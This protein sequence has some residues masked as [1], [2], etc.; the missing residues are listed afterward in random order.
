MNQLKELPS[1]HYLAA[2]N[3]QQRRFEEILLR[4]PEWKEFVHYG[5]FCEPIDNLYNMNSEYYNK[6]WQFAIKDEAYLDAFLHL[7][8]AIGINELGRGMEARNKLKYW[9]LNDFKM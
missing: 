9:N 8:K 2:M 3:N 1:P 7:K 4:H 5:F 6:I